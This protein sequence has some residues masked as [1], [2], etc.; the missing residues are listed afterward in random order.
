M[1]LPDMDQMFDRRAVFPDSRARTRLSRLVGLDDAI[2]RLTKLLSILIRPERL[3]EWAEKRH[4]GASAILAHAKRRHPLVILSGDVGTGKTELAETIGD[5]IA[6]D[7]GIEVMLFPMSL[8]AR[9][10]GL[11]GEMSRLISGAFS[12]V[13][14]EGAKIARKKKGAYTAGILL[15]IDEADAL[16]QSRENTQMHHEDRAG[17]NALIR[18]L[19]LINQIDIPVAVVMCT[20]R[21]SSIDPA[22]QRRAAEIFN[23]TR[24]GKEQRRAVI[25]SAFKEI[26]FTDAEIEKLVD[27]TGE[28]ADNA[29]FTFSDLTQRLMCAA[30]MDAYP[31]DAVTFDRV[32]G[33]LK[34]MKP[35]P[36]FGAT[37]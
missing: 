10:S 24:P 35:T 19:D 30:V 22:V 5:K 3:D 26:G 12:A 27:M 29:G 18:G 11:V 28:T 34:N 14:S 6:R 7:E 17:V 4:P 37:N 13:E 1:N 31:G 21:L 32:A 33:I 23:F 25:S 8:S 15:L 20:N 9:G 2:V 36:P 16:S